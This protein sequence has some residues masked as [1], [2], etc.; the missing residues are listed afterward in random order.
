MGVLNKAKRDD[1]A[2]IPDP[3]ASDVQAELDGGLSLEHTG[4]TAVEHRGGVAHHHSGSTVFDLK[5]NTHV[6]HGGGAELELKGSQRIDGEMGVELKGNAHVHHSGAARVELGGAT[7][8]GLAGAAQLQLG[9][10]EGRPLA[11]AVQLVLG[12]GG[13]SVKLGPLSIDLGRVQLSPD[14]EVCVKLFGKYPL[15]SL[16]LRGRPRLG[17][18]ES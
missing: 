15:F 11:A 18:D 12:G 4:A 8:L 16:S 1:E 3:V 9:N 7:T 5:G 10:N 6:H 13:D 17:P 14:L 2:L